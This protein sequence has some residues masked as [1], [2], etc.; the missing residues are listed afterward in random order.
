MPARRPFHKIEDVFNKLEIPEGF[1]SE[2]Q[3]ETRELVDHH[4]HENNPD[5][6]R[7]YLVGDI[8]PLPLASEFLSKNGKAMIFSQN[9]GQKWASSDNFESLQ[10]GFAHII[11]RQN[12]S[13]EEKSAKDKSAS[14][15]K[16][17]Q[18]PGGGGERSTIQKQS[19]KR[20]RCD[21]G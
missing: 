18:G 14:N 21:P 8:L 13:R 9:A 16:S 7:R 2:L 17:K 3:R 11:G 6:M 15:K 1:R 19:L 12:I 10:K 4:R 5:Q 20:R